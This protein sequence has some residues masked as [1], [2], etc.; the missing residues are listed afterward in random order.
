VNPPAGAQGDNLPKATTG[1]RT[2][3][4]GTQKEI[5][6]SKRQKEEAGNSIPKPIPEWK[7]EEYAHRK[8]VGIRYM[9]YSMCEF[10]QACIDRY[11]ELA[12]KGT[13]LRKVGTPFLDEAVRSPL[14]FGAPEGKEREAAKAQQQVEVDGDTELGPVASKILMKCLYG[15]RM[16][17]FDLLRPICAL[18]T[19]VTKWDRMCD[20]KLH[21][22]MCYINSSIDVKM[23]GKVGD[24]PTDVELALFSDADFAGCNETLRS[25]SGVFLKL[26]GPNTHFPFSALSVKQE[27]F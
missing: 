1:I 5:F 15:A 22:L 21:R 18:A 20:A 4:D 23:Y 19:K 3:P 24:L 6:Q 14:D 9:E 12:P 7:K 26:S 16:C 17:R 25:T 27:Y 2:M 13:K 11:L 8:P 10:W